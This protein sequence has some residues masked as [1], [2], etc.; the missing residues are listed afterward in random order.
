MSTLEDMDM[1]D[2]GET[3]SCPYVT[4]NRKVWRHSE[5]RLMGKWAHSEAEIPGKYLPDYCTGFLYVFSP[6]VGLALA[7]AAQ[8]LGQSVHPMRN[9]ED[10]V[11]TWLLAQGLPWVRHR[12]LTALGVRAWDSFFSH[13][14]FFDVLRY[15]FNPIAVAR[16]VAMLRI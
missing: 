14:P 16:T 5:A 3:I 4:R 2:K 10:Y 7:E 11:V 8:V 1:E 15:S 6:R 13:C 9:D 12:S